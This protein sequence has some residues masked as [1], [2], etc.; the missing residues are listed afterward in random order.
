MAEAVGAG[1][2]LL[3]FFLVVLLVVYPYLALGRIWF[4]SKRQVQLMR[5]I[6]DALSQRQG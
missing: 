6:R 4:Y 5:E 3:L 2:A 1:V